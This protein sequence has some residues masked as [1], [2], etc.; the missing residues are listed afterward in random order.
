MNEKRVLQDI[1]P[2][3]RRTIRNISINR[4]N[5]KPKNAIEIKKIDKTDKIERIV[6]PKKKKALGTLF[7]FIIIFLGVAIIAVASSL[8]YLKAVVTVI[9][10]TAELDINGTF[11]ANKDAKF[12]DLAYEIIIASSSIEQSVSAT[13]GPMV[14]TKASGTVTLYNE[15]SIQQTLITGTRLSNSPGVIYRTVSAIIIPKARIVDGRTIPG[16]VSVKVIADQAGS[17]YNN[18]WNDSVLNIVAFKGTDRYNTVYAKMKTDILGGFK[19]NKKNISAEIEKATVDSIKEAL[20]AELVEKIKSKIS[21]DRIMFPN[22]Y[23]VEYSVSDP[24]RKD[25]NYALISVKATIYGIVFKKN[26]FLKIIAEK[27]INKFP[28]SEYDTKGLD[29]I[30]FSIINQKDFSPR[31]GGPLNFIVKGKVIIT[32]QFNQEELKDKLKGMR[33]SNSLT[34]FSSY[35]AIDNAYSRITPFWMRSY[36]NLIKDI[37]IELKH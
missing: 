18:V 25:A 32:G 24:I 35:P 10:K 3:D 30:N 12:P 17:S 11:T 9:P 33:L 20:K 19:G 16:S 7:T 22:A 15:Q 4:L 23:S 8:L 5:I 13:D 27:D 2:N 1:V 29:E 34:I 36:P 21:T 31:Q 14:E 37:S 26:S 28:S 6:N